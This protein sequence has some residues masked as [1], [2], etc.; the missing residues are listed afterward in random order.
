M[1]SVFRHRTPHELL[2]HNDYTLFTPGMLTPCS[3]TSS[4]VHARRNRRLLQF[5]RRGRRGAP[6]CNGRFVSKSWKWFIKG[7]GDRLFE[8]RCR[9]LWSEEICTIC[10]DDIHADKERT[11]LRCG[12]IFHFGC[13][14]DWLMVK[15]ECPVCRAAAVPLRDGT[16][17]Q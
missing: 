9:L 3:S 11:K 12:H 8:E 17:R 13:I 7:N 5:G 1:N 6:E 10:Q 4:D 16:R 2:H 15:N 14:E